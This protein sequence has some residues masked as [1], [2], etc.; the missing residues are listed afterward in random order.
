MTEIATRTETGLSVA[1]V[2]TT[3][4]APYR[5]IEG[6]PRLDLINDTPERKLTWVDSNGELTVLRT[7]TDKAKR[8]ELNCQAYALQG[9]MPDMPEIIAAHKVVDHAIKT[10]PTYRERK[11]LAGMLLDGLGIK[12]EEASATYAEALAWTLEHVAPGE[13][14][15]HR[16]TADCIDHI[17]APAIAAAIDWLWRNHAETYGRP[18]P[19]HLVLEKCTKFRAELCRVRHRIADYGHAHKRLGQLI[20]ATNGD[21]PDVAD[22]ADVPF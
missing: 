13:E 21:I 16:R 8:W 15:R 19:I 9:A 2:M 4:L 7:T 14:E 11:M 1:K 18:P 17:P 22:D 6:W 20:T 3:A 10:L 12:A 5:I